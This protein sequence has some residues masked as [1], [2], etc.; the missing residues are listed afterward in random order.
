[1]A[2]TPVDIYYFNN[3]E[4]YE[5]V[6]K[7][8]ERYIEETKFLLSI[9]K[10]YKVKRVLDVGCGTGLHLHLLSKKEI[11]CEGIDL[12]KKMIAFAKSRYP[13]INFNVAN[14]QNLKR[15]G[16]EG[17]FSLCTTFA[18]NTT[19]KDILKT[20]NSFRNA[21]KNK[22]I[23]IVET[24]NPIVFI[25]SKQFKLK[26]KV[27]EPYNKFGLY[28]E[29][30]HE[31]DEQLQIMIETRNIFSN[32]TKKIIRKD[33]LK[34]RLF[35]PQEIKYFFESNGFKVLKQINSYTSNKRDNYRLIT[36]AQKI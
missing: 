22:G 5:D 21:L 25:K 12:N 3:P 28:C 19:N 8:K 26:R 15:E 33:V 35:F 1:M 23:V 27:N 2:K 14:M 18:Y 34:Y 32:K 4:I 9:F 36:V 16:F 30:N 29:V 20:I 11:S 10:K 17:I 24:F 31:I 6:Q 7:S 13:K